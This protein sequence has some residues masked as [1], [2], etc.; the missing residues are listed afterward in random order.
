MPSLLSVA[1]EELFSFSSLVWILV[2][3]AVYAILTVFLLNYRLVLAEP[4]AS[5][6][7][8]LL[9]G[10]F[11]AFSPLDTILFL[12]TAFLVGVNVLLAIKTIASLR[13]NGK[14]KV[15]LT[16]GAVIGLVTTGCSSCG[17]SFLSVMGLGATFSF[18]PFHGLELHI[19]AIALLLFSGWY[20]LRELRESVY[21][22]RK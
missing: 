10:M 9:E 1:R 2:F 12:M 18:L 5:I 20:M 17:F 19:L 13:K 3:T 11:T 6:V 22:Q 7:L 21:C 4:N 14:I 16:T 8:S 15:S